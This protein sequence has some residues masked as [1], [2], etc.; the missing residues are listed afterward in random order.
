MNFRFQFRQFTSTW[1][2]LSLLITAVSTL[3]FNA[4][5]IAEEP[6]DSSIPSEHTSTLPNASDAWHQQKLEEIANLSRLT[7]VA[8][9][10]ETHS[11]AIVGQVTAVSQLSD[12]RPTDWAFQA[13]Q[14]LVERYGCIVG[15]PDKT[16][17]GN[18]AISRYEFAAG[19][20]ACMDR[21]NELLASATNDLVRKEDLLSLQKMQEEFAAELATWRGRVDA[22]EVR[23]ATLERQQFS[24]TT[25]LQGDVLVVGADTFGDRANNT[26]ADDTDDDTQAFLGYRV[27]LALPT[28]FTG[29]DQ[30]FIRL[31][32]N[33]IPNLTAL[34]GTAMTRFTFDKSAFPDGSLYLD[35]LNYRFPLGDK[36]TVWIGTRQL[37]PVAYASNSNP[38]V[39][40]SNGA[41][42]RFATHNPT[43]FRPGFDGAGAALAYQFNRQ[44]RLSL[45]Y[46]A[47]DTQ[48]NVPES[49]R[50]I[51]N[52]N[53]LAFA[54]LTFNPTSTIETAF[55]YGRKYFGS[56]TGFNLTGGTGSTFARNPFQLNATISDNFGFQFNWRATPTFHLGGWFGYTLAHQVRGGDSNAT[57]LNGA[58]FLAFPDLFAKGNVGGIVVGV[59]PKAV[60]NDYRSPGGVKRED[61]DTSLHLEAFYTFRVTNGIS[62]TPDFYLIT[63]PEHND[64]NEPIWV[65]AIR[66][67]FSF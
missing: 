18:Q 34:T 54:Q 40:G 66:T 15:Y 63:K 50:G 38:L 35:S 53:N 62:I 57:I 61:P 44:F 6:S 14:S 3:T 58:V 30:L 29:K 5:A 8:Q 27:R 11:G 19:L 45:A 55:S 16:Y 49:G 1:L 36:A 59:P 65:G 46:T 52:G 43:I 31:A 13:L 9:V 26:S 10:A 24:T 41:L 33:N 32:A 39:G 47:D 51:F 37:Q 12:V 64:A 2:G 23:T 17:R 42:S 67:T 7:P 60:S 22:L 48:A 28:S 21:I 25:K 20:N 56:N 4:S